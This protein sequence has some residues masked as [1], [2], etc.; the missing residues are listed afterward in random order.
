M[1]V[2]IRNDSIYNRILELK[3]KKTNINTQIR[4]Q[5]KGIILS[6]MKN[7]CYAKF[8]LRFYD[9]FVN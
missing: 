3:K 4:I 1:N 5:I 8:K 9:N 6:V 2:R 7:Q